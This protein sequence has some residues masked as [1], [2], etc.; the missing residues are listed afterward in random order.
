MIQSDF[1]SHF[2][3]STCDRKED[4]PF[5]GNGCPSNF[6]SLYSDMV[7]EFGAC[8]YKWAYS[9]TYFSDQA[10]SEVTRCCES[11]PTSSQAPTPSGTGERIGRANARKIPSQDTDSWV[12][13]GKEREK[14]YKN[15]V[16]QSQWP[17]TCHKQRSPSNGQHGRKKSS[18]PSTPAFIARHYVIRYGI[19]LWSMW[20]SCP[21]VSPL[22]LLH[23]PSLL[24][25]TGWGEAAEREKRE[26]LVLAS[27][28]QQ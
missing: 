8:L 17:T 24:I 27:I 3:I 25:L 18:P 13:E 21:A 9:W 1:C 15:H 28:G 16:M 2:S 23:S 5:Q 19:S 14:H 11:S 7:V 4:W 20:V 26:S 10:A 6:L 22:N 12:G